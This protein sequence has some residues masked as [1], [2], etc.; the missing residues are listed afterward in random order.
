MRKIVVNNKYLQQAK[1]TLNIQVV[2][3][4]LKMPRIFNN[5]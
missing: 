4:H 1:R 2:K 3:L 5:S